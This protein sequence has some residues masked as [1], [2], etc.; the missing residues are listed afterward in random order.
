[1]CVYGPL[2]RAFDRAG[3]PDS[4]I[5]FY[6]LYLNTTYFMRGDE[7]KT[8]DGQ[9]DPYWSAIISRRLGELYEQKG[10]RVKAADNYARFVDLWST[11][12]PEFQPLVAATRAALARL[13]VEGR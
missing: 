5:V 13:K 10:D 2:G 4:A 11:A 6:E 7:T 3:M 8:G 12:D 9:G 1:M